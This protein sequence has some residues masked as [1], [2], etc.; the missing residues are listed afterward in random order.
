MRDR[1]AEQELVDHLR[2]RDRSAIEAL[3]SAYGSQIICHLAFAKQGPAV[4]RKPAS[5]I[6]D[7]RTKTTVAIRR[8]LASA[9]SSTLPS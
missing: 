5:A 3:E 7:L 9:A 6:A 4:S 2:S 1:V 8:G